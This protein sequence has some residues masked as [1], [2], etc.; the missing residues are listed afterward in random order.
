MTAELTPDRTEVNRQHLSAELHRVRQLLERHAARSAGQPEPARLDEP[1][2]GDA[3]ET[4]GACETLDF[5]AARFG[6]SPFERDLLLLCAGV[7]LDAGFAA[8]CVAAQGREPQGVPTFGL[9]LAALPGAHWSALAPQAPLRHWRLV[10]PEDGPTLVTSRLRVDERILHFLLGVTA[11]DARL[12]GLARVLSPEP[13][14]PGSQRAQV[15]RL[16]AI[17]ELAEGPL[18]VV[19]LVGNDRATARMVAVQACEPLGLQAI[20]VRLSDLPTS[21]VEREGVARLLVRECALR[22]AALI[23][24]CG[25]G[26]QTPEWVG[27]E[28]PCPVILLGAGLAELGS[29]TTMLEV[30][31]ASPDERFAIWRDALGT[32]ADPGDAELERVSYHF[33]LSPERIAGAARDAR[34]AVAL[35]AAPAEAVWHACRVRSRDGLDA[36]AQRI[37]PRAGWDD[38]VL[39]AAQIQLLHDIVRQVRHRGTVYDRWGFAAKSE[40]GLG[41]SALFTGE[42]GTGKTLAAEVLAGELGLDL[43][44]IDLSAVVSKY[45]GET[46]KNLRRVFDA[47][48]SSGAVLLFDEADALFGKRSEVRDSHDRYANIELA[49]LLQRMETYRGLAILTT[50]VKAL[51][52]SAFLRRI[53]FIVAFSFPDTGRRAEIWRR[54]F[55]PPVPLGTIRIDQLARLNVA[56]GNIRNIALNA[57]F[58]A[59]DEGLP[60]AMPHLLRATRVEY[61]KLEKTLTDAEIG[62][63]L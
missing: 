27:D 1:G 51:L 57:A 37:D 23:V 38:L 14:L 36:L 32:G 8:A 33:S 39:P 3:S 44:R 24:D 19:R 25:E 63:W 22:P 61:A 56:G 40:R 13:V 18:P 47:A 35:G 6:L 5:I 15:E 26:G 55:P 42:S 53:R 45:I 29:R 20:A 31:S 48:D 58:F 49:Y 2:A 11:L 28:L 54:M 9:A 52:D 7:E 41:I 12:A 10:E 34:E 4:A 59:A 21:A 46:E 16:R 30:R 62:G 60:L 43:Y 17:W 50:N